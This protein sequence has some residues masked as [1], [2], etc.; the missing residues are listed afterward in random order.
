VALIIDVIALSAIIFRLSSFGISPNKLAALGENV[1]VFVNL[2]GMAVLYVQFFRRKISFVLLERWQ[3]R[4]LPVYA[5]WLG[6]V[7]LLFPLI[8]LF[9]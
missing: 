2:F 3:T 6:F 8:F 4:Y 1:L 9:K 7:G 5:L